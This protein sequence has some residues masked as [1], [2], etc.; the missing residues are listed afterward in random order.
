[1][2]ELETRSVH[3][4]R[5]SILGVAVGMAACTQPTPDQTREPI[6]EPP[7]SPSPSG[8]T[9]LEL[10]RT[11]IKHVIFL[12]KE[13]RS[14][15]TLFGRFP[16]ADGPERRVPLRRPDGSVD[17]VRLRTARDRT[18]DVDHNFVS[19]LLGINGGEMDGYGALGRGDPLSTYVWYAPEQ[20]PAYWSYARR[21]ELADRF[22]SAV[23]GP[24]GP[25]QLWSMAGSSAGFTTFESEKP[26]QSYG[27]GPPRE[28]CDDPEERTFRFVRW[29]DARD[30]DVMDVEY[31]SP[32]ALPTSRYW[33]AVWPCV[34]GDPRFETLPQQLTAKGVSWREYR[35]E[36]EYVDP[37]RQIWSARHDPDIWKHRTTPEQ[38]LEDVAEGYLPSVSWLTPPFPLSEHPPTSICEG[39]NWTVEMLNA[40]MRK[41]KLWRTTAVIMTWD[42]FGGFYD[43][44]PPPHSDIYGYG[45]RVP[46]IVISPWARR[47]INHESM[48]PD[49]VL[50]FI[51]TLFGVDPLYDQRVADPNLEPA[52]DPSRNDLLGTNGTTGAFQFTDPLPRTILETRDCPG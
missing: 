37:L 28:Y 44:V 16:G 49:S 11:H 18:P 14:F 15:D 27:T 23:Y 12:I 32:R 39:E 36:N 22:F 3:R 52:E 40:V 42:D 34:K 4:I 20:I 45:P 19:G 43:H 29:R 17:L 51:E 46:T 48:S 9:S 30:P 41:P 33:K 24:T 2:G 5:A 13:N 26:P 21:Y 1:M 7:V 31:E 8:P 6:G 50:N 10:A 35:G 25:E 38:Y 47:T